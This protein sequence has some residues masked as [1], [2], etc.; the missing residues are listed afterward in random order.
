MADAQRAWQQILGEW[1]LAE[2]GK[3][4]LTE[5]GSLGTFGLEIHLGV[6][7]L[8]VLRQGQLNLRTRK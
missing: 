6:S 1:E 4:A 2:Q 3:F 5:P 8:Q 7:I